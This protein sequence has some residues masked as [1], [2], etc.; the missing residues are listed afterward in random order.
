MAS[1]GGIFVARS[2]RESAEAEAHRFKFIK[3]NKAGWTS[4]PPA[5]T[6]QRPPWSILWWEGG[7]TV[8]SNSYL[9]YDH[10]EGDR[11]SEALEIFEL[12]FV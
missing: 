5:D 3:L 11:I 1:A 2:L 10:T 4:P 8:K 6:R 12:P 7:D 9:V